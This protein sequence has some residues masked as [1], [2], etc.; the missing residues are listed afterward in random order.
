[1]KKLLTAFGLFLSVV[2]IQA[3][4]L[5]LPW[6][7][8]PALAADLKGGAQVFQNNCAMCHVGGKNVV[9][10]DKTLDQATLEKYGKDSIE[11]IAA[12]I[13]SGMNAIPAFKGKLTDAQIED[14]AAYVLQQA[15]SGWQ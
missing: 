8:A 11:A 14:V 7:S 4:A 3:L 12:Q 2:L 5:A 6:A 15:E 10:P 9:A 1:M 13:K